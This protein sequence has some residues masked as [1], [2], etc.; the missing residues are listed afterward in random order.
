MA[1]SDNPNGFTPAYHLSGGTIRMKE[2]RI[3]D[4]YSEN[5]FTGDIVSLHTDGTIIMGAA[6]TP[7]IGVFAGCAYTKD[8]G[9]IVFSKY[10]ADDQSISGSFATAYVFDDPNIVFRAQFS[11]ASG[12]A[13]IGSTF[14]L[15][16]TGGSTS[17]GRSAHE[18]DSA[19][20]TDVLLRMLDFVGDPSNDSTLDNAEA[21]V[22]IS[23][24]QLVPSAASGDLS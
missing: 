4:D 3:A 10:W 23:E 9:E 11:G 22:M 8:N 17:T 14:D 21:Y 16:A 6:S 12:V 18:I 5:I 2:Y 7:A 1:N 24:H 20:A 15:L 19:D 13:Q